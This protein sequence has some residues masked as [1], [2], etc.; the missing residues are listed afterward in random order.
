[1]KVQTD[2]GQEGQGIAYSCAAFYPP[3]LSL[4]GMQPPLAWV[5]REK[6]VP[7]LCYPAGPA[8]MSSQPVPA[9]AMLAW[10]RGWFPSSPASLEQ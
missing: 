9:A 6:I 4:S 10:E 7:K 3:I 2:L 1:M 5:S 8:M